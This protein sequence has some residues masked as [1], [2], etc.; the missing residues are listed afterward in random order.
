MVLSSKIIDR[1]KSTL[2]RVCSQ[3]S[4]VSNHS[5][6]AVVVGQLTAGGGAHMQ[7]EEVQDCQLSTDPLFYCQ[8]IFWQTSD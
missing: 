8:L 7:T 6:G 2:S 4:K 3:Q 1:A 5:V